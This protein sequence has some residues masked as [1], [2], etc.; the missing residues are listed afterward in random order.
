MNPT[1]KKIGL[2]IAAPILGYAAMILGLILVQDVCFG[3]I[4]LG[5]T[6]LWKLVPV[7]IGSFLAAGLGGFLAAKIAKAY[8][9]ALL[10]IGG[11]IFETINLMRSGEFVNPMWFETLAELTLIFGILWG[12]NYVLKKR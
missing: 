4:V 10:M 6:P 9:P 7:A 5:E 1:L 11:T 12:A 3:R 2:Y 8:F